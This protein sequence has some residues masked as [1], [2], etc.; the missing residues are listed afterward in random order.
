MNLSINGDNVPGR[1][2][3]MISAITDHSILDISSVIH[4]ESEREVRFKLTRFPLR[5]HRK[6]L[7]NLHDYAKRIPTLM[8]IR[9]VVSC[10]IEKHDIEYLDGTIKLMFG[11]S[12][13]KPEIMVSSAQESRGRVCFGMTIK[14]DAIDLQVIDC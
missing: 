14:I 9:N 10:E 8:I 6:V 1:L 5:K 3:E 4:D 7:G 12:A 11:V 13:R 2:L